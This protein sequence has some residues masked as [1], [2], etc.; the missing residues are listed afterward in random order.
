MNVF[1]FFFLK[2]Q[3]VFFLHPFLTYS[4]QFFLFF[5]GGVGGVG[6]CQR[7]TNKSHIFELANEKLIWL[8]KYFLSKKTFV[9][10]EI[11]NSKRKQFLPII[12]LVFLVWNMAQLLL[13]NWYWSF[14]RTSN[15]VFR[16]QLNIYDGFFLQKLLRAF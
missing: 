11:V 5:V 15:G 10:K 14:A 1:L 3:M 2:N 8:K 16:T 6:I 7:R 9:C 12:F 4:V 13:L